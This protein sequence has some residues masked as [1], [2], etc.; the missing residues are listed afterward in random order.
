[1]TEFH[2]TVAEMAHVDALSAAMGLTTVG[3]QGNSHTQLFFAGERRA[4][5][6]RIHRDQRT[7]ELRDSKLDMCPDYSSIT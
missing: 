5:W 7:P 4:K 6:R 3:Q 2:Q 1:M